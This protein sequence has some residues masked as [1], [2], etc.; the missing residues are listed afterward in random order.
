VVDA[1]RV[2]ADGGHQRCRGVGANSV[3]GAQGGCSGGGDGLD[4]VL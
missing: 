3:N 2:V 4:V 1:V